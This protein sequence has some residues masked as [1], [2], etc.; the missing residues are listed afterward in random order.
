MESGRDYLI[1]NIEILNKEEIPP[2][3]SLYSTH[4]CF[5][6]FKYNPSEVFIECLLHQLNFKVFNVFSSH[7]IPCYSIIIKIGSV[8]MKRSSDKGQSCRIQP[9]PI[10]AIS[11][12]EE[13]CNH[14]QN[15]S[16]SK[17]EEMSILKLL[18]CNRRDLQ[19]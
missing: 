6:R 2:P 15:V 19:G 18:Y 17:T 5:H 8:G 10:Y 4:I 3:K 16:Y 1:V 13:N 7:I 12:K 11:E 14:E 9:F